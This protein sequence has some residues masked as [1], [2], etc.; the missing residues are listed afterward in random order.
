MYIDMLSK[1]L[2]SQVANLMGIARTGSN[3]VHVAL[4]PYGVTD[5]IRSF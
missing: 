2:R 3:P 1:W 5:S 4:R